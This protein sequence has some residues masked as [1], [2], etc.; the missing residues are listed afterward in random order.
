MRKK[1]ST[2]NNKKKIINY[3]F[4]LSRFQQ[5]ESDEVRRHSVED[6]V[7]FFQLI[8]WLI[9]HWPLFEKYR[10]FLVLCCKEFGEVAGKEKMNFNDQHSYFSHHNY[11]WQLFIESLHQWTELMAENFQS[12]WRIEMRRWWWMRIFRYLLNWFC[13]SL[14]E[15]SMFFHRLIFDLEMKMYQKRNDSLLN[16]YLNEFL[17]FVVRN[18]ANLSHWYSSNWLTIA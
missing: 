13:S 1:T 12:C 15:K 4:V 11:G 18:H 9:E 14:I 17:V 7:R 3:Y 16:S 6:R 10:S 5:P 8:L 2:I